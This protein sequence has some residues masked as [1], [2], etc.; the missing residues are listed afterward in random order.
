MT[1]HREA[2]KE[3][4]GAVQLH[5]SFVLDWG[6]GSKPVSRYIQHD[7]CQFVTIDKNP[8]I[9]ADRRASLH[10]EHDIQEPFDIVE[11]GYPAADV[12]FCMEVLE[13]TLRPDKVLQNIYNNLKQGGDLY[14]S[15]PYDFPIHSEDDYVRLTDNG[16]K[17]WL[18][19]IGFTILELKYSVGHE[20]YLVRAVK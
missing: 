15:M 17:A 13:H 1:T 18:N 11:K 6:S 12:A 2:I 9:A 4:L 5:D 7:G 20:G 3:W 10:Y 14:L 8:L 19:K 16:L